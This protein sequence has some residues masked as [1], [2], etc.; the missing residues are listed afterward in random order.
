VLTT[1]AQEIE[2]TMILIGADTTADISAQQ[3]LAP[4]L[5]PA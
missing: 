5:S 3:L 4:S 2:R 1:L